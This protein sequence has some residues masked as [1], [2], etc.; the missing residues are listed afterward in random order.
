MFVRVHMSDGVAVMVLPCVA[1]PSPLAG[2]RIATATAI[3]DPIASI[4][5]MQG[6]A[7]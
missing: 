1:A 7:K 5:Q 3:T 4:S 2:V 6:D